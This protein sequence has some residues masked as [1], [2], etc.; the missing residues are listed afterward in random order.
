MEINELREKMREH[1]RFTK[2]CPTCNKI[3]GSDDMEEFLNLLE[4]HKCEK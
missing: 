2:Y 1:G 4:N 3:F